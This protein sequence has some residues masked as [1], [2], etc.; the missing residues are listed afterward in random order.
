[1]VSIKKKSKGL[2]VL[3][4][5]KCNGLCY[6]DCFKFIWVFLSY[7]FIFSLFSE[8]NFVLMRKFT[9]FLFYIQVPFLAHKHLYLSQYKSLVISFL[10]LQCTC[11]GLSIYDWVL[12]YFHWCVSGLLFIDCL[13][14][15]LIIIIISCITLFCII[16]LNWSTIYYFQ[17]AFITTTC[18]FHQ[19]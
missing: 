9:I 7:S 10:Y 8:L 17:V 12:I 19:I 18:L 15:L 14:C 3:L 4:S 6:N 11:Y 2:F 5:I 1:M 16:D 13:V